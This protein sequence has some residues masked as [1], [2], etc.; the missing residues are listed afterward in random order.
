[1]NR[2]MMRLNKYIA[3]CGAA[4]RRGA[5]ELI[6]QARVTVNNKLVVELGYQVN[7]ETDDIRLDG[8]KL[9]LESKVYYLLNK[10][11]GTVTTTKDEKGRKTV[12]DIIKTNLKIFPV[13][14]LDYNTT[15]V[16]LITNDGEFSNKM[17]HPKNK[18]PRVYLTKLDNDLSAADKTKLSRGIILDGKKS[19]FTN[20]SFPE[21]NNYR[22]VLVTTVE[23]RNHF[24]KRMFG[25]LGYFVKDLDR[26][27]FGSFDTENLKKGEYRE[28]PLK[29]LKTFYK[30]YKN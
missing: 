11:K 29:E 7:E 21:T 19:K 9:K 12:N 27:S 3:E 13:G 22:K 2:V 6:E 16:L 4:S 8:E 10:P 25:S 30:K 14:R 5:D 24:V 28:I 1:M 26:V 18:I 15:G 20:M 17:T 23:G